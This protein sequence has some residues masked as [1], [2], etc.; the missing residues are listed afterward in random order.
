MAGLADAKATPKGVWR[1]CERESVLGI[2]FNYPACL[3]HT[4]LFFRFTSKPG[5]NLGGRKSTSGVFDGGGGQ[6]TRGGTS[7]TAAAD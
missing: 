1:A 7:K 6:M 4:G 5:L 2:L 3:W